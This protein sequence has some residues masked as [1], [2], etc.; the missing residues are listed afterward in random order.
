MARREGAAPVLIDTPGLDPFD[1]T[2]R[3]ELLGLSAIAG[4][5]TAMVLPAGLDPAEARELADAFAQAGATL[6]I[7]TRLDLCRRLGGVLAAAS[8]GLALTEAGV[9]PGA[10]DGLRPLTSDFLASRLTM[11]SGVR[12]PG[13]IQDAA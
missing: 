9:G 6:L 1:P 3:D 5:I 13:P 7:A 8:A 4:A 2:A 10:A 12:L 11:P